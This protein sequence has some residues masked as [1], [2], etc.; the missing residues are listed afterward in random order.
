[1]AQ[2]TEASLSCTRLS[3]GDVYKIDEADY[4]KEVTL[5]NQQ[6]MQMA[7]E[8]GMPFDESTI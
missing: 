5:V 2:R 1:M 4:E 7:E 8:A 3:N 6:R